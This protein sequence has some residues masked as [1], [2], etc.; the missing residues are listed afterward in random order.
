MEHFSAD[1]LL[2]T[3]IFILR[4]VLLLMFLGGKLC[5]HQSVT[6][7]VHKDWEEGVM[8]SNFS[9]RFF[10]QSGVLD[11]NVWHLL[12]IYSFSVPVDVVCLITF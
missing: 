11:C 7:P 5:G 6:A 9:S 10:I 1:I 2:F 3:F 8:K 12:I 4:N